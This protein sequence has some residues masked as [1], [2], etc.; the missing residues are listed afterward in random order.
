MFERLRQYFLQCNDLRT[1]EKIGVFA[2]L[3]DDLGQIWSI[4]T[5]PWFFEIPKITD[6]HYCDNKYAPPDTSEIPKNAHKP[7]LN[8]PCIEKSLKTG[9]NLP[10]TLEFEFGRDFDI[11]KGPTWDTLASLEIT[12]FST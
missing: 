10:K 5:Y 1:F 12:D 2:D 9:Q 11:R 8:P 6:F 4:S 7:Y 3:G